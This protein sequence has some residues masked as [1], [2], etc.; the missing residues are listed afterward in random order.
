M[1]VKMH[2]G[3]MIVAVFMPMSRSGR[4]T[5][6][7]PI[8]YR[9]LSM[10]FSI[11]HDEDADQTTAGLNEAGISVT[12]LCSTGGFLR[13]GNTTLLLGV[14]DHVVEKAIEIIRNHARSRTVIPPPLVH[15]AM[16]GSGTV[17]QNEIKVGGAT[18]FVRGVDA[19]IKV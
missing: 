13:A 10:I 11:M 19:M 12:R 5:L 4:M 9:I 6:S 15:G 1:M 8:L 3:C 14:E 7:A 18:V 17:V 16:F 2:P